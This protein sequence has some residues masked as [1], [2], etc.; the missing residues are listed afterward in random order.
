VYFCDWLHGDVRQYD[1]TDTSKPKLTGQIWLGGLLKNENDFQDNRQ[2][3]GG[4]QMIQ[5]SLDG[6]RL[7]VT[8]HF[9][10]LGMIN[11]I[12]ALNKMVPIWLKSIVIVKMAV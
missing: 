12:R 7:Y 3:H 6:K 8:I 5:L 9:I 1:I 11:S 4:P 10:R 2:L